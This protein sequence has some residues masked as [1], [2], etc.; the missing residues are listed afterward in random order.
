MPPRPPA[1]PP[2][3]RPSR[4]DRTHGPECARCD[5]PTCRGIRARSLPLLGGRRA[6]YSHE[7]A[8]AAAVQAGYPH[9]V[10]W[11]GESNQTYWVMTPDG[12]L[13]AGDIDEL[14]LVLWP[15]THQEEGPTPPPPPQ[16]GNPD[17]TGEATAPAPPDRPV[18]PRP[19]R[20]SYSHLRATGAGGNPIPTGTQRSTRVA[21]TDRRS[22]TRPARRRLLTRSGRT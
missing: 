7:H 2:R 14:L 4:T 1:E 8:R 16:A 22:D 6:E 18:V 19:R 11:F 17:P 5:H 21:M 3:P 10:I 9:L 13:E 15:H 20:E 12:L